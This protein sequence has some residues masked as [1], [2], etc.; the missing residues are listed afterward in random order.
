[1]LGLSRATLWNVGFLIGSFEIRNGE[2]ENPV[3][4]GG[5]RRGF[6]APVFGTF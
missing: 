1:M 6:R 2:M 4:E 3:A 5:M